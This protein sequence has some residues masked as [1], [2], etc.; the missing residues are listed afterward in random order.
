MTRQIT[1][2][3]TKT[4]AEIENCRVVEIGVGNFVECAK[5]GPV[6]CSHALLIGNACLCLHPHVEEIVE[7]TRKELLSAKQ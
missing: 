6:T 5:W 2:S 7:N 1:K 4:L 3:K